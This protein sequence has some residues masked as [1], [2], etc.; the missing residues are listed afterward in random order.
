MLEE[1]LKMGVHCPIGFLHDG[2]FLFMVR[3][4]HWN[5]SRI[6]TENVL[7]FLM[8]Q[9]D[10]MLGD[11]RIQICGLRVFID[12]TGVSPNLLEAINP[13]KTIKDLSKILQE[14][15]PFRMKG[16]IYYN[17]P[18]IM[19]VLFKLLSLWLRQKVKDRF[20]RV[21]GNIKKAYEKVPGLQAVLPI[22]YG[23]QNRS[24]K[25]ILIE[26]NADFKEYFLKG[27][28]LWKNMSVNERKRPESAKRLMCEYKEADDSGMRTTGTFIQLPVND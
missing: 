14:A 12:F 6:S 19:E 1:Y 10:R 9:L 3:I 28:T 2:T 8:I 4:G 27:E 11:P 13:K 17:E 24:I 26:Q 25:D 22:D 21:K 18:Q 7:K 16:I 5:N 15:Y 23:G 20:I